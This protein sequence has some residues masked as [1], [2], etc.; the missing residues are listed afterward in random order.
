MRG[1]TDEEGVDVVAD[2]RREL[3]NEAKDTL[4]RGK[5]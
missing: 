3:E 2:V 4:E 1:S 5:T